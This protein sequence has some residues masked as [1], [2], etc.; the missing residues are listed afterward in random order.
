MHLLENFLAYLSSFRNPKTIRQKRINLKAI[1]EFFEEYRETYNFNHET[2]AKLFSFLRVKKKYKLSTIKAIFID[3]KLY[4][5]YL[6]KKGFKTYFDNDAL[7]FIFSSPTLKNEEEKEKEK[8]QEV[9]TKEELVEVLEYIKET[10]KAFYYFTCLLAFSGLRLNEALN[11]SIE[12]FERIDNLKWRIKV[13]EA[14]Y[15]K[16]RTA[17]LTIPER[18]KDFDNYLLRILAHYKATGKDNLF[19]YKYAQGKKI[20]RITEKIIDKF[21]REISK[22]LGIKVNAHK[23]RKTLATFLALENVNPAILKELLGHSDVKT[24]LKYYTLAKRFLDKGE[25]EIKIKI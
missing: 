4:L 13:K 18:F 1:E 6:D 16:E 22:E 15:G 23:F 2:I 8:S 21:Y 24:T 5:K 11:L 10:N 17:I 7:K 3:L 14:K 25:V 19:K 12:D 20:Y 9:F